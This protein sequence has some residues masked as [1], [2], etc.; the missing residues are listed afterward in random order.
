MRCTAYCTAESY[1]FD[2]LLHYC[3]RNQRQYTRYRDVVHLAV[4]ERG[5]IYLFSYGSVVFWEVDPSQEQEMLNTI[6]SF[7]YQPLT[8]IEQDDFTFSYGE[9]AR[10]FGEEIILS[11]QEPLAKLA[12]SHGLAQS[13][14]LTIFEER[15]KATIENS[16][17]LASDLAQNG[18]IALSRRQ[19]AQKMGVLFLVRSDI[20]LHFDVLDTPEIF[21]EYSHLEPYYQS[22][23]NYLD[24]P[25]RVEFLNVRLNLVKELFDM[26]STNL[27]NQHSAFLEWIVIA[28]IAM[29]VVLSLIIHRSDILGW[30]PGW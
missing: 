9:K 13:V 20:N 28:L 6:R 3:R 22:T 19:I 15:I 26:L 16:H 8:D 1:N 11:P 5:D 14:K 12:T 21:W 17:Y 23:I 27:H 30:L 25:N 7:E 10:I 29:E 4:G 24:L 2:A 18:R